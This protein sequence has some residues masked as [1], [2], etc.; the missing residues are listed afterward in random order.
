MDTVGDV[1]ASARG[2]DGVA[3]DAPGRSTGYSSRAFVASTWKAGNLLRHYGVHG[4]ATVGVDVGRKAPDGGAEPGRLGAAADPLFAALGAMLLGAAVDLDPGESPDAAALVAPTAWLDRY[5]P[6]PGCA[7]LAYGGPPDAANVVHFERE[8]WSENPVAPPDPVTADAVALV[9]DGTTQ[10]ALVD[11]ALAAVSRGNIAGGDRVA[12]DGRVTAT[13]FGPGI[14]A[15]LAAGAR[16]VGGE[17]ADADVRVR[18]DGD[19]AVSG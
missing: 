17:A 9:A 13:T 12:I 4:G 8:R 18:P 19:V 3:F 10:G 1:L 6:A 5:D 7:R 16:I 14:L 2:R 15:P 11:R